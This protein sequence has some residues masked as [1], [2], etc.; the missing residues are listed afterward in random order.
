MLAQPIVLKD[1]YDTGS[2]TAGSHGILVKAGKS[3]EAV[4]GNDTGCH[5]CG[6][7]T[8]G[9]NG[10]WIPDHQPPLNLN[11][12]NVPMDLYPHCLR[13]SRVQGGQIRGFLQ[14]LK[15]FFAE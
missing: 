14:V 13:C 7:K 2:K 5:S 6:S 8:P 9:T 11:P 10:N 4:I 12:N 1:L 3:N 15:S